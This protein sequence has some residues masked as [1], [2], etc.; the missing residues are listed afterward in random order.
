[1]PPPSVV[2]EARSIQEY[3]FWFYWPFGPALTFEVSATD[4][5]ARM[6]A[7]NRVL[8]NMMRLRW[9]A[10]ADR[11]GRLQERLSRTPPETSVNQLTRAKSFHSPWKT[12]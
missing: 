3:S 12:A 1:M 10:W 5:V 11:D 2:F 6:R 7:A 4:A 8:V 9:G